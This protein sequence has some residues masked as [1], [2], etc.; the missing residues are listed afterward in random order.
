MSHIV[1]VFP[2]FTL[3][4]LFTGLDIS[5]ESFRKLASTKKTWDF[6]N[7]C[8]C[9]FVLVFTLRKTFGDFIVL[10]FPVPSMPETERVCSI[11]STSFVKTFDDQY[12]SF[13][14]LC[15]YQLAA[16]CLDDSFAIHLKVTPHCLANQSCKNTLIL[17]N[18][19]SEVKVRQGIP[20]INNST[21]KLP[22]SVKNIVLQKTGEY[23][24][25]KGLKGVNI[26]IDQGMNI[27]I[28]LSPI[29]ANKTCGICG[30][31]NGN[32]KDDLMD[33]TTGKTLTAFELSN[34][35]TR[36]KFGQKCLNKQSQQY[37]HL[38]LSQSN[39]QDDED[40]DML[41]VQTK[42]NLI[43]SLPFQKCHDVVPVEKI[44]NE[45]IASVSKCPSANRSLCLCEVLTHYSRLCA[46][47]YL[48]LKWRTRELCC[49]FVCLD[50]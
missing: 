28:E 13:P 6:Y 24:L 37:Q 2:V 1:L 36:L 41:D 26:K 10:G 19:D 20:I 5:A 16:D 12:F 14:G 48:V 31:F 17:Y 46:G 23:L 27:F 39:M 29:Y 4:S 42:C 47:K 8:G 38:L 40:I 30:N 22:A 21:V 25:I 34:K 49:K 18:G 9:W 44:Y 15:T 50:Q 11:S 7:D 33:S 3:V 32:T 45:C 35:W 43:H